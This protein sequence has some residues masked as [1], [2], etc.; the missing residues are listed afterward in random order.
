MIF[1]SPALFEAG[2]EAVE[3][4]VEAVVVLGIRE[5]NNDKRKLRVR[6]RPRRQQIVFRHVQNKIVNVAWG[7]DRTLD[8]RLEE[9]R[10]IDRA[11]IAGLEGE[12]INT[13]HVGG[14]RVTGTGE[15][16][17]VKYEIVGIRRHVFG[18]DK[19][20][21]VSVLVHRGQGVLQ[22]DA[23]VL[24]A[25]LRP[26]AVVSVLSLLFGVEATPQRC[27]R[28]FRRD[29]QHDE[30]DQAECHAG[31][32]QGAR[33]NLGTG[34]GVVLERQRAIDSVLRRRGSHSCLAFFF[35]CLERVLLQ[36]HSIDRQFV[37]AR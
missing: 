14:P 34:E 10:F 19:V 25:F 35:P 27:H 17:F 32:P 11:G 23:F 13:M 24:V 22:Q 26:L 6:R 2:E 18:P 31:A 3:E 16:P 36:L 15:D 28:C 8:P 29:A 37:L 30:G 20:P 12:G 5:A 21:A 9:L 4:A 7:E 33:A 1:R